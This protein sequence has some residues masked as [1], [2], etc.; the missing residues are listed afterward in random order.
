M[1]IRSQIKTVLWAFLGVRSQ[2]GRLEDSKNISNPFILLAV[3]IVVF[4]LFIASLI[5]LVHLIT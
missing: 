2:D 1:N 4:L 3:A 5:V